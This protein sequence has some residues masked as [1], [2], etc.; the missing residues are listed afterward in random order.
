MGRF[1]VSYTMQRDNQPARPNLLINPK[2]TNELPNYS[3]IRLA[4]LLYFA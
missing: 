2:T 1:S 3:L 4:V